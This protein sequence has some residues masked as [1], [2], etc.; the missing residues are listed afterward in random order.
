MF[1]VKA[2]CLYY[3]KLELIL[4]SFLKCITL[5]FHLYRGFC[6]FLMLVTIVTMQSTGKV[7][8]VRP[9]NKHL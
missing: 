7:H 2:I 4:L 9:F 1:L 5:C 8:L 3:L 6:C